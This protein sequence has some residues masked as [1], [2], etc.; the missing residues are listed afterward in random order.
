MSVPGFPDLSPYT[1]G[2]MSLGADE[3]RFEEDIR[4]ARR[5]ME[6]GV[7][8]HSS[9]TYH[10]GFTYMVL[11]MAFDQARH[12]VPRLILK[13]RDARPWL[14]RFEVEDALRRLGI[15]RIDIAQ[16]VQAEVGRVPPDFVAGGPLRAECE[17]LRAEGKV[18]AFALYC[19]RARCEAVAES[20]ATGAAA[21]ILFYFNPVQREVT[22]ALWARLEA[23]GIP[24]LALRTLGGAFFREGTPDP[25]LE[26]VYRE[27]GC[28]DWAEFAL[29]YA[30]SFPWVRTTIGGTA[31]ERHLTRLLE[32]A[33]AP[34]PLDPAL[35]ARVASRGRDPVRS[36]GASAT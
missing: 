29:R 22:D 25:E 17:A 7:W 36:P 6:A 18:G 28:A 2:T 30:W 13:I 32:V 8:F 33:R 5:A 12:Q 3:R 20:V 1:F 23:G 35:A 19:D 26:A 11:R 34:R 31:S 24:A 16:L 14:L 21:G 15:D 10:R 4:L 27:S 9:P